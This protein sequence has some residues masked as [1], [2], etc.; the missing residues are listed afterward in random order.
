LALTGVD[1]RCGHRAVA[2][3][4]LT[5]FD[6][7]VVATGVTPRRLALPG[8]DHPMVLSYVDVILRGAPVGEKVAIIG[9]GGIGFDVAE[10]L[11]HTHSDRPL[12]DTYLDA[13]GVDRSL[14]ARGGLKQAE[15]PPSPR[16]IALCQRKTG[17]LGARLGKTTGWIHRTSMKKRNV[18]MLA[19]CAYERID[20]EGL[21]L[22]V[23]GVPRL[24][25]V[26]NVVICAGQVSANGLVAP[27]EAAGVVVDVIG[28]AYQVGEL[29]ARRAIDQGTRMAA[30]V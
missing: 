14:G 7:V 27:L 30:A 19:Q 24:L 22:T 4:L 12:I 23:S 15:D 1:V 28:G 25:A 6:R 16:Q 13:W 20:D 9:A 3:D 29:D 8:H 11:T 17:K 2:A 21:H 5:G 26:D 10:F 18:E